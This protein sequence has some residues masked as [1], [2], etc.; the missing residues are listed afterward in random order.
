MLA[1]NPSAFAAESFGAITVPPQPTSPRQL[2]LLAAGLVAGALL[3][4][5]L[6][7]LVRRG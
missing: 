4:A 2:P 1:R 6:A 3:A 7:L 5:A